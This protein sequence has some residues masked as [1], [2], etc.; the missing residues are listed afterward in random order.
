MR[1]TGWG[2]SDVGRKRHHNED[3]IL[4]NNELSLFAVADG[5]GGHLGGERASRMAV[6]I[7]EREIEKARQ[8]GLLSVPVGELAPGEPHP[9]RTLLRR[10]VVEAD[11]NIYETATQ[12]PAL[13]GMGTT[14]TVLLFAGNQVH[15]GHVGDSRA[16][17]YRDGR[18]RQLTEDHSWIQEQV[19]AGLI[20]AE[21]AKESRFRNIIT[22]SV[23]FEPSV[24]PDLAAMSVEAGDC[25]VLCS[26]G[27]SNYL[28]S[29]ELGQVLTGHFYRDVAKVFVD[30]A[31]DRGGD[32]NV[33]CLVV[34]AGNEK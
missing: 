27:L 31:N 34:Y 16:Y 20:S 26:D 17:L 28:S 11:R 1:I 9:L 3:S 10:A 8:E 32:D 13:A 25:F 29:D 30:L 2:A 22:R 6:E 14:L 19:R 33:T 7:L 15:M 4:C 21:E 24:E 5:M 18:A 23:G 12:N